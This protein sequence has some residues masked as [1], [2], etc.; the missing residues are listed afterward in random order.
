MP[1]RDVAGYAYTSS[2]GVGGY[3]GRLVQKVTTALHSAGVLSVRYFLLA[4]G[5][6]RVWEQRSI[7]CEG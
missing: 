4:F 5:F 2:G 6:Y 7:R 1:L 3:S